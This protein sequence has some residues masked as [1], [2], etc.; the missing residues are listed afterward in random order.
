LQAGTLPKTV[1]IPGSQV[2][3]TVI[4]A[5]VAIVGFG[6]YFAGQDFKLCAYWFLFAGVQIIRRLP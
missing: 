2:P 4:G 3:L 6:V 1:R 5:F